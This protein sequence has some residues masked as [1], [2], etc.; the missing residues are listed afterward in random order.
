[1]RSL[2]ATSEFTRRRGSRDI[3]RLSGDPAPHDSAIAPA[4]GGRGDRVVDRRAF[5]GSLGLLAVPLGTEAQQPGKVY[6]VGHLSLMTQEGMAPYVASLESALAELGY[7]KGRNL[8]ME[9][10]SAN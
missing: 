8:I 10:R 7:V 3:R 2:G 9:D 1:M 6:R 5:L 4:R